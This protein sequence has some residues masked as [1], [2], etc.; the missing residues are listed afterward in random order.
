MEKVDLLVNNNVDVK[1]SLEFWGDLDS[2]NEN[3]LEFKNSL[4]EKLKNLEEDKNNQD[5]QNYSILAH[6]MKSEARY[7]G[8]KEEAEIFLAHEQ[9][10]K[11][12]EQNFIEENYPT[13]VNTVN[14][15]INI[16][17]KYFD[18]GEK[19]IILIVDDSNIILNFLEKSIQN[20][21]DI[22]KAKSGEEAINIIKS[23]K[24]YAVL[25]DLNM[26]NL[27][28]FDVLAFMKEQ[29]LTDKIPVVII[30]GDDTEETIKKA[31][32][33][34]VLDVLNKPFTEDN[35]KRVLMSI[36]N[37]YERDNI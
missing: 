9:K 20:E 30:T 5:W 19:K 34:G 33:Y 11:E 28:G 15:I 37:S 26:P 13:L 25:L 3:L 35:I 14:K 17:D 27:N 10:G 24:L 8:F 1:G 18:I 29:K 32:N 12:N 23:K 22:I 36:K 21:F 31:F 2:Y 16:L 6:S 7:L 4:K